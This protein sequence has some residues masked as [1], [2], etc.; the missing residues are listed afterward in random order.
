MDLEK[1]IKVWQQAADD[2]GLKI[3]SPFHLTTSENK[4]IRFE[5][6][7]ENFGS[8]LGTIIFLIDDLTEIRTP[9]QYGYFF[10]ALNPDSFV[11]YDRQYFINMLNDWGYFGDKT[12]TPDWYTGKSWT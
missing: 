2:L 8:K 3:Q 10:S 4:K 1:L 12:K 11:I 7:V 9:S 6:L 5:L